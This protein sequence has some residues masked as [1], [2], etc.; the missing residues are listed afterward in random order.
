MLDEHQ[1][2]SCERT[3]PNCP[4]GE[5]GRSI[6]SFPRGKWL[7]QGS[8]PAE[9]GRDKQKRVADALGANRSMTISLGR[10]QSRGV[11][12]EHGINPGPGGRFVPSGNEILET[13]ASILHHQFHCWAGR[14]TAR[15]GHEMD[16]E[17][18]GNA[19]FAEVFHRHTVSDHLK[20]LIIVLRS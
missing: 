16:R 19:Q 18:T 6:P 3:F 17:L 7:L 10:T 14:P 12:P 1:W 8:M 13:F 4:L 9:E 20:L 15:G 2:L 11:L 5:R